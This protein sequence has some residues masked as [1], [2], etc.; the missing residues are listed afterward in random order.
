RH[1]PRRRRALLA[2]SPEPSLLVDAAVAGRKIFQYATDNPYRYTGLTPRPLEQLSEAV[3]EHTPNQAVAVVTEY[4]EADH[5][6]FW[7]RLAELVGEATAASGRDIYAAREISLLDRIE[8]SWLRGSIADLRLKDLTDLDDSRLFDPTFYALQAG[9]SGTVEEM[10]K[11]FLTRGGPRGLEPYALFD[12]PFYL[13]QVRDFGLI[14]D[15]LPVLHYI[16]RGNAMG[17][18]PNSL[19]DPIFYKRQFIE[20]IYDTSLLAH[21]MHAGES[22]G[23]KPSRR[24]DPTWYRA[25]HPDLDSVKHPL[26]HF[27]LFGRHEGRAGHPRD[28]ANILA[29]SQVD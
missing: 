8:D 29:E 17:L 11:H 9:E 13:R 6:Q 1:S 10:M 12:T 14:I 27:V 25:A 5:R 23:L 19:F 16:R 20:Q 28:A 3:F 22:L 2:M 15:Q 18:S 4:A 26:E 7:K 24:F 21:Y